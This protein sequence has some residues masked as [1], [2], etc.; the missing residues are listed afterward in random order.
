MLEKLVES[1]LVKALERLL[2]IAYKFTSPGRRNVPDRLCL[3]AIH[4]P[5]HAEIVARYVRFVEVKAPGKKPTKAQ[6]REHQRLRSLGY[7]VDVVD[8]RESINAI[9]PGSLKT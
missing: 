4:D 3:L 7:Q 6:E 5:A 1:L 2:G 9:Y 8:S